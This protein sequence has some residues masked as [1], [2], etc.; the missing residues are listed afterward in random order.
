MPLPGSPVPKSRRYNAP[1]IGRF[2]SETNT[3]LKAIESVN[4]PTDDRQNTQISFAASN[5]VRNDLINKTDQNQVG[6]FP[7]TPPPEKDIP[8]RNLKQ[9]P[10]VASRSASQ[11]VAPSARQERAERDLGRSESTADRQ[12][13]VPRRNASTVDRRTERDYAPPPRRAASTTSNST[14]SRGARDPPP[15]RRRQAPIEEYSDD[16]YDDDEL[17]DLYR[18]DRS[19]RAP[20]VAGSRRGSSRQQTRR[21][22]YDD[23][24]YASDAY[25]GSSLDEGEFE[26]LDSRSRTSS[27]RQPDIKKIKVKCHNG[28]DTRIIMITPS[29]DYRE[30]MKRLKD[31]FGFRKDVKCKIKDE[32]GEMISLFDQEDLEN[33]ISTVKAAARKE[34]LDTGKMEVW[35]ME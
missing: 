21:R 11:R 2:G 30:F 5:L 4:S 12:R 16:D 19:R 24:R 8:S 26:M 23:D 25:E 7:P 13:D 35:V 9:A 3:Q 27:R 1:L 10:S 33:A 34:K 29:Q 14:R 15:Q 22:E 6:A 32:D 28:D 18:D 20:S 17:Y 31:K